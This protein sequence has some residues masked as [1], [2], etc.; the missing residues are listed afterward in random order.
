MRIHQCF[1]IRSP[2]IEE[3]LVLM[4]SRAGCQFYVPVDDQRRVWCIPGKELGHPEKLFSDWPTLTPL[5]G[6][7]RDDEGILMQIHGRKY[8]VFGHLLALLYRFRAA[9][10]AKSRPD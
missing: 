3:A 4:R 6:D 9:V 10:L 1:H 5:F 7:R 8:S 2:T